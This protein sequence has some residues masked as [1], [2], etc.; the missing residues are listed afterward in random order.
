MDPI[1]FGRLWPETVAAV[2]RHAD[3]LWPLAAAFLFLPQLLVARHVNDRLPAQLFKG[4]N[5]PGDALAAILLILA[6]L[7][8]QL[9]MARLIARDGTDGE[10]LGTLLRSALPLLPAAVAVTLIQGIGTGFGLFLFVIPGVWLYCRLLLVLPLVATGHRDPV[11]AVVTSWSLTKGHAFRLFGMVLTLL[12]GFLL[13]A[14][15]IN[16]VGAA[17]GV[18]ST[19][20]TG[21]QADGWSFARWLFEVIG[22]AASS[23]MG[24]FY[25]AFLAV[26]MQALKSRAAA[27]G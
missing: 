11:E 20:A 12:F 2:R 6:S 19:L 5:L 21:G 22:A 15:G 17:A 3:L 8:G 16:G 25:I 13:L 7:L 1:S 18:I 27:A 10:P 26:V 24:T 9:V 23:A 4:E 14:I